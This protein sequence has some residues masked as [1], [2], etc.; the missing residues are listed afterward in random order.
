MLE[1]RFYWI[2]DGLTLSVLNL[3]LVGSIIEK[4]YVS[5]DLQHTFEF[6]SQIMILF[7]LVS[8]QYGLQ[9]SIFKMTV[10][11]V[12]LNIIFY[13]T[14]SV[15]LVY[16]IKGEKLV[17]AMSCCFLGAIAAIIGNQIVNIFEII[18]EQH[19]INSNIK[20]EKILQV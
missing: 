14:T 9:N 19:K 16:E 3:Q 2:F 20:D 6:L 11:H 13:I 12:I 7:G 1:E 15:Y 5:Q 17:L 10:P 8:Y 18:N 4:E